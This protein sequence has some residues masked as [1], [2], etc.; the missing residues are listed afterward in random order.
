MPGLAVGEAAEHGGVLDLGTAGF[1]AVRLVIEADA[2]DF[3]RIGYHWQPGNVGER[4]PRS[5]AGRSRNLGER[6]GGDGGFQIGKPVTK[7]RAEVH[8]LRAVDEAPARGAINFETCELHR[9]S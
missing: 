1:L 7:Q 6:S 5:V 2:E 9:M 8:G 4:M 3:V